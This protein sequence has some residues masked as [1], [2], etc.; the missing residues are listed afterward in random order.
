VGKERGFRRDFL[1]DRDDFVKEGFAEVGVR[2][3]VPEEVLGGGTL[4]SAGGAST[5]VRLDVL[6]RLLSVL[7]PYRSSENRLEDASELEIGNEVGLDGRGFEGGVK[8]GKGGLEVK[9]GGDSYE[10]LAVVGFTFHTICGAILKVEKELVTDSGA[11]GEVEVGLVGGSE[12]DNDARGVEEGDSIDAVVAVVSN[13]NVKGFGGIGKAVG[14]SHGFV[15]LDGLKLGKAIDEV[16]VSCLVTE[17]VA[18]GVGEGA[19]EAGHKWVDFGGAEKHRQDDLEAS[20]IGVGTPYRLNYSRAEFVSNGAGGRGP[21]GARHGEGDS[22]GGVDLGGE[23]T[24]DGRVEDALG[25]LDGGARPLIGSSGRTHVLGGDKIA[26]D[27]LKGLAL[28]RRTVKVEQ[29]NAK[30][31]GEDGGIDSGLGVLKSLAG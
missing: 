8:V 3:A 9:V 6:G 27:N 21:L 7:C 1:H 30:P 16:V 22:G 13:F 28:R 14:G 5:E 20:E 18:S 15:Y 25:N 23:V 17:S 11:E 19:V 12:R 29:R 10:V 26:D 4:S 24:A 2:S 31:I